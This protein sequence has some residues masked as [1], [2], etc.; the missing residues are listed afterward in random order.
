[1]VGSDRAELD[2]SV[3]GAVDEL[4]GGPLRP[5][6]QAMEG[7]IGAGLSF[8]HG[9]TIAGSPSGRL[10]VILPQ[11]GGTEMADHIRCEGR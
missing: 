7:R 11:Y 5:A 10:V 8:Q 6:P 3:P 9:G 4:A 2:G 1:M